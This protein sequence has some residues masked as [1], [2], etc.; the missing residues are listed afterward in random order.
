MTAN[1]PSLI[2]ANQRRWEAMHFL[3][4]HLPEFQAASVKLLLPPAKAQYQEISAATEVPWGV[5]AVIH[6]RE[7]GANFGR[8]LAQGD[9]LNQ[10]STHVP[11]GQGPYR[12]RGGHSAFYWSALVALDETGATKWHDWSPG[13]TMTFLEKYNGLGYANRGIPSPYIWSG[14]TE[15]SRGKYVSDGVFDPNAVDQQLGCAGLL[16]YMTGLDPEVG[17]PSPQQKE[18]PVPDPVPATPAIDITSLVKLLLPTF[19]KGAGAAFPPFAPW[20]SAAQGL[21]DAYT[22]YEASDKSLAA[23]EKILATELRL[24]ADALDPPKV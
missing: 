15:Y 6:E 11:K 14:T 21:V 3:N 12:D 24:V 18:P 17:Y 5:V 22:K 1:I 10:V 13:G 2:G 7:S 19:I 8:Q 16:R 23:V 4:S 20:A 9:P